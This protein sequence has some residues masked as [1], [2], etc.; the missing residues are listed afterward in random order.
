[1][2]IRERLKI[3]IRWPVYAFA[4]LISPK[5]SPPSDWEA[6]CLSQLKAE[7]SALRLHEIKGV[8][9]N[10]NWTR[11][12]TILC[13]H[14]LND[15]PRE[16]LRWPVVL[17]TMFAAFPPYILRELYFLWRHN[18]PRWRRAIKESPVGRPYR[19]PLYPASSGNAIHHAY[20]LAVFE[21][22]T[23]KNISGLN[24]IVE[25]GGGYGSMC[26][27]F[28]NAGFKGRYVI[29]D[30]PYFSALQRYF[31]KVTRIIVARSPSEAEPND[32][33]CVSNFSDLHECFLEPE[34]HRNSLLVA[35]WSLSEAPVDVRNTLLEIT[36]DFDFFLFGYQSE[37]A[38]VDNR[39]FFTNLAARWRRVIWQL[40]PISHL[41]GS[42]YLIGKTARVSRS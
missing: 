34:F 39:K 3:V 36:A 6:E 42:Y 33:I 38:G 26:R 12:L 10:D 17:R 29:F 22:S 11:N 37:F 9:V 23:A 5:L 28:R 14:I 1:M 32:V 24:C 7:V 30:L 25:F 20:H 15:N 4:D 35:T 41:P 21:D 13:N 19:Y 18:W 40:R 8:T 16:F 2:S 27:L 31:L